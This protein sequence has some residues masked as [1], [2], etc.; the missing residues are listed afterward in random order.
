MNDKAAKLETPLI[1]LSGM[2][3]DESVFAAQ[4]RAFPH[5]IVPKWPRPKGQENFEG[6]CERLAKELDPGRPCFIGG[7]SFGGLVALEMARYLNPL[8]CFLIGSIRGPDQLPTR[9]R[10]MKLLEPAIGLA[11]VSMLQWSA[12][13]SMSSAKQLGEK[14]IHGV[15]HQFT[16][17][18]AATLRW[19]ARQ[20][21][22][23]N[24]ANNQIL[25]RQIHGDRD[26]VFPIRNI[27]ADEIVKGGG[28]VISMTHSDQ[29][30]EFL[31]REMNLIS[32]QTVN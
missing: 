18:D 24:N 9:I 14:H 13:K 21:L 28:H 10:A 20:I 4:K 30:T 25:I 16:Q 3:A 29:V 6:Y 19:S 27:E 23:W 2:G 1:L 11:P 15:M 32:E 31:R 22:K 8:A 17:A 26:R 5:L 12:G 7:A